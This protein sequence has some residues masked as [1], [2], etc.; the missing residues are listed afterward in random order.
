[1][2]FVYFKRCCPSLDFV[3]SSPET[4][5]EA[6][7]QDSMY[8]ASTTVDS[9]NFLYVV[10]RHSYGDNSVLSICTRIF[11]CCTVAI[12]SESLGYAYSSCDDSQPLKFFE[13]ATDY[14]V[15]KCRLECSTELLRNSCGC[16]EPYMPGKRSIDVLKIERAT[17]VDVNRPTTT[18]SEVSSYSLIT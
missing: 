3:H 13:D 14:T 12:Q 1:M 8:D 11:V 18:R 16:K 15:P 10:V 7:C 5:S 2:L 6:L 17:K 9:V 4:V